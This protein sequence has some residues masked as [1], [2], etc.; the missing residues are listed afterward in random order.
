M[1]GNIIGLVIS[2]KSISSQ[3]MPKLNNLE[4]KSFKNCT[5]YT[6]INHIAARKSLKSSTVS[7]GLVLWTFK[8]SQQA[9]INGTTKM[10]SRSGLPVLGMKHIKFESRDNH[11]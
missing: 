7:Y 6:E 5:K 4:L 8:G 11:I 10:D 1:A 2:L 3:N 9:A